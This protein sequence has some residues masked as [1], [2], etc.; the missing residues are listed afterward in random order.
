MCGVCVWHVCVVCVFVCACERTV[1]YEC[2]VFTR[3]YVEGVSLTNLT[4]HTLFLN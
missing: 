3:V 1:T 4:N 2:N